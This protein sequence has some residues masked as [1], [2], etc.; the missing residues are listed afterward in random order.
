[1]VRLTDL[2]RNL[3]NDGIYV[4]FKSHNFLKKSELFGNEILIANVGAYTGLAL[5]MKSKQGVCT[6]GPNMFLVRNNYEM[7]NVDYVIYLINSYSIKTALD[8]VISSTAQ[9]K[10]NKDNLKSLIVPIPPKKE[11]EEIAVALNKK[12]KTIN[13]VIDDENKRVLL[14]NEYRQSLISSVV[15]GKLRI[16]KDMI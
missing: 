2:R 3:Q 12:L 8:L 9:P 5:K 7:S 1:M 4:S 14:L 10:I 6:L 11:Q 16:T 13:N 15:I